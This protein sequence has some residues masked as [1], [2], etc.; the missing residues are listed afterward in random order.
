MSSKLHPNRLRAGMSLVE[1]M[2]SI[3]VLV[4]AVTGASAYSYKASQDT[5]KAQMRMTATRHALLM[6]ES[7]RG[8]GGDVTFDPATYFGS[9]LNISPP[10][11]WNGTQY[12]E[13]GFTLLGTYEVSSIDFQYG[14]VLSWQDVN[15]DLRALNVVVC[16]PIGKLGETEKQTQIKL[17]SYAPI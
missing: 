1:T 12:V 13:S 17:T 2:C 6:C 4:V 14:F 9:D 11:E 7:W 5:R 16:W 8:V 15:S 3:T 10:L